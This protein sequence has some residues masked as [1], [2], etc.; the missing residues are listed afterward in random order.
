VPPPPLTRL[1]PLV[2]PSASPLLV[3]LLFWAWS[4]VW[5]ESQPREVAAR[6]PC[7]ASSYAAVG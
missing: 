7:R 5:S 1:P 4:W 6:K 3:L 2:S